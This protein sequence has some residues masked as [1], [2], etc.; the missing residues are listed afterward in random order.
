MADRTFSFD[1]IGLSGNITLLESTEILLPA[2]NQLRAVAGLRS[3]SMDG[4]AASELRIFLR[5]PRPLFSIIVF[6]W[7]RAL[8]NRAFTVPPGTPS[9]YA[10]S[11]ILKPTMPRNWKVVRKVGDSREV[12][13]ASVSAISRSRYASSGPGRV[14]DTVSSSGRSCCASVSS[15]ANCTDVKRRRSFIRAE[16]ITIVVSHVD[17]FACPLNW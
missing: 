16:L 13:S 4:Y 11:L 14:S 7:R 2:I 3:P 8:A 6:S 17:I 10:V 15:K 9:R 1:K 5:F 12:A